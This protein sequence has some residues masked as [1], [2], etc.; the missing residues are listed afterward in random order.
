M[1]LDSSTSVDDSTAKVAFN[2]YSRHGSMRNRM[3]ATYYLGQAEFDAGKNLP[4]TLHFLQAYDLAAQL[5]DP[6]YMGFSSQRLSR[7]YAQ[8]FDNARSAQYAQQAIYLLERCKDTLSANFSRVDLAERYIAQRNYA[9]AETITD[10]LLNSKPLHWLLE[11]YVSQTK[12]NLHFF[13][14]EFNT[15][16]LYYRRLDS[17]YGLSSISYGRMALIAEHHGKPFEADSMLTFASEKMTNSGDSANFYTSKEQISLLR[18]D[19]QAAYQN[20]L[21]SSII[22]DRIVDDILSRS[23]SQSTQTYFE[24]EYEAEKA[25]REDQ[26]IIFLLSSILL[27]IIIIFAISVLRRQREEVVSHMAQM[28]VLN[29]ELQQMREGQAGAH[30]VLSK[31][32]Q[33]RIKTMTQLAN[34]YMSWSDEAVILREA[35]HGKTYKEDIITEFRKEI[36]KLRDDEHFIPSIEDAL[37]TSLNGIITRIRQDCKGIRNG[38]IRINEKD[39]QL[40]DLFFAGFSNNT[41]AFILDMTDDAVRTRKKNLRKVFLSMEN[42][43]GSEYLRMLSGIR[44]NSATNQ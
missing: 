14:N 28:E 34:A 39:F 8:N 17:L 10:S 43:H 6:S 44:H 19:Y 22:Q 16:E 12:A 23:V 33:D 38:D 5:D 3:M 11:Y 26:G 24:Q 7:L 40:L 27:L 42:G 30:A 35:Q 2:Y 37:N 4:A 20:Q 13:Q 1:D 21:Q 25:K 18:G 29:Q 31:L 36:R 15:A 32:V 9:L 41:V